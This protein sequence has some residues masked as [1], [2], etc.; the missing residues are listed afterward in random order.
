ML[1][2]ALAVTVFSLGGQDL[3]AVFAAQRSDEILI[4]AGEH[5]LKKT[6]EIAQDLRI[7]FAHGAIILTSCRKTVNAVL[8]QK[9]KFAS[10]KS[11]RFSFD[12]RADGRAP[13]TAFVTVGAKR[14]SKDLQADAVW[15]NCRFEFTVP[16]G[17]TAGAANIWAGKI[18]QGRS[19]S[20][21]NISCRE[22]EN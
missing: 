13:V 19:V 21:R 11:F 2:L 3:D 10:G 20:F 14:L 1:I 4:P 8:S 9:I 15:R 6:V 7:V 16:N 5:V 17:E 12:C 22:L 18:A